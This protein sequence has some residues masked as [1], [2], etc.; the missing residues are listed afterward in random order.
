MT[1]SDHPTPDDDLLA[2]EPVSVM[3]PP[4]VGIG[5]LPYAEDDDCYETQRVWR[6][7]TWRYVRI[8]VCE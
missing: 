1:D 7:G 3:G 8:Y 4:S 2:E 5:T 6:Y